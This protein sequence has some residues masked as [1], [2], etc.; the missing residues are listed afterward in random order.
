MLDW[1]LNFANDLGGAAAALWQAIVFL[2]NLIVL[3]A[4]FL[5][6]LILSVY[7]LLV[8]VIRKVGTFFHTLWDH[9]FKKIFGDF[10]NLV[11]KLHHWLEVH[12]GPIIKAIRTYRAYLDRIFRLYIK[13]F[14][15]LIQHVRQFLGVLRLLGVKW[16]AALDAKLGK[17]EADIAGLFL[18]VRGILTNTLDILNALADP[19]NLFRRP[20]AVLSI[21]RIIPSL[22]RVTTGL[23]IGFFLPS[24][25]RGAG[26]GIGQLPF[27][28]DATDPAMNPPASSYFQGDDGLGA[29][30]GF[31]NG[32]IPSDGAV[33]D[34][35]PLDYFDDGLY[36]DPNCSD[37]VH[38]LA[39]LQAQAYASIAKGVTA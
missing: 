22:V 18:A 15:N 2:F 16:A 8:D 31:A 30:S 5:L 9:F 7:K 26:V 27:N 4:Q 36:P 1:L 17:V 21:R 14:L 39:V 23:P 11:R 38:C 33:D 37:P 35:S 29:F 10:F 34:L 24:P 25:R 12:L 19:L 28:F 3:V 32:E 6:R 20:T 13:P